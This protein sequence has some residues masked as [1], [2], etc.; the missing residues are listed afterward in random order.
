MIKTGFL[1][2]V[3]DAIED[4][5]R[6]LI[7]R[8]FLVLAI[9]SELTILI[10]LIGDIVTGENPIEIGTLVGVLVFVPV[11][12]YTGLRKNKLNL[13]I[14]ITVI[15]LVFMRPLLVLMN[16]PADIF[17]YAL[18]YI[19]TICAGIVCV[20]MYNYC[21]S[22]MRAVGNSKMPLI[23]LLCSAGTNILLDL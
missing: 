21:A 23:F 20:I 7:E 22:L 10:A 8:V 17:D 3:V 6:E 2:T 16:T 19:S 1:K 9:I 13:I 15:G 14:R 18:T 11:L 4:P 12:S 5:E